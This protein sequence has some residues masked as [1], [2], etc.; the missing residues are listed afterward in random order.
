MLCVPQLP[1][2]SR[3]PGHRPSIWGSS[4]HDAPAQ[5]WAWAQG[6]VGWAGWQLAC[7]HPPPPPT[8]PPRHMVSGRNPFYI[9]ELRYK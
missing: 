2:P 7:C 1:V 8:N 4:L 5:E 9:P 3:L 6:T